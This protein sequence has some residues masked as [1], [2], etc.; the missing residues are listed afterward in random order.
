MK[1]FLTHPRDFDGD[2]Q[3]RLLMHI[4]VGILMGIP[5]LGLPLLR[6]FIRYEENEDAHTKD[7]AWKDYAGAL[8]G[9]SIT[10]IAIVVTLLVIFL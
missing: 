3:E 9:I 1:K 8:V 5:L 6:L 7:Q 10:I 4:P 2:Y